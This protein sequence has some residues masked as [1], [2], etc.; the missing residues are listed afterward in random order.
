MDQARRLNKQLRDECGTRPEVIV[1]LNGSSRP[2]LL[3]INQQALKDLYAFQ[4][5]Y[6][7]TLCGTVHILA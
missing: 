4:D 6:M 3:H 7:I 1:E 2:L 5:F